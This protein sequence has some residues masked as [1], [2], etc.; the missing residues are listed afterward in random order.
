MIKF[1]TGL[2][3]SLMTCSLTAQTFTEVTGTPFDGIDN[4]SIA[5]ADI[6]NDNDMDVVVGPRM[7][8]N[9]GNGSFEYES[10]WAMEGVIC[11]AFADID[12]DFDQ[13]LII[14]WYSTTSQFEFTMNFYTDLYKNNGNGIFTHVQNTTFVPGGF[15]SIN[16]ADVDNDNDQDVII[17]GYTWYDW[18]LF[19]VLEDPQAN[20]YLNDGTGIFSLASGNNLEGVGESA[21]AFGDVDGDNDLD[22]LI[23]GYNANYVPVTNLYS[24]NGEG[25]FT[26]VQGTPFEGVSNGYFAVSAQGSIGFADID[27][28]NDPDIYIS[29]LS[30]Q[31]EVVTKLYSNNGTG[32]FVEI[33]DI[34]FDGISY[35][36]LAFADTDMD[37]DLDVLI[38]GYTGD[39]SIAKLYNNN[40]SGI[41]TEV[42]GTPFEG[43]SGRSIAIA[44][45]DGDSDQDVL[46][47]GINEFDQKI[48]KL[49]KNLL[50]TTKVPEQS[51]VFEGN[52]IYPNPSQGQITVDLQ[53]LSDV[54]INVYSLSGSLVYHQENITGP[55]YQLDLN[56]DAGIYILEVSTQQESQRSK[57]VKQ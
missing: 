54:I 35:G 47:A 20:L 31:G 15:G 50:V 16:F 8:K 32:A 33:L 6:D 28:D 39:E 27:N 11:V 41:F 52:S 13:D 46:I 57:L 21:V 45:I 18:S 55:Q 29:G 22:V 36:S 42:T 4:N 10:G 23:T 7:F 48:V 56:A 53:E 26:L 3:I 43:I 1:Y 34:P 5:F 44:D 38:A 24:N 2:L 9:N 12:N 40:G 51:Q 14:S 19:G 17:T 37:D 49:Y 25:S 30:G